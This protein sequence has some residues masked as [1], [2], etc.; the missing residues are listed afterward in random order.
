VASERGQASVEWVAVVLLVALGL[1]ALLAFGPRVDGRSY[2]GFLA[3]KIACAVRG[4]CDDGGEQLADAYG[5]DDAVLVRRYAPG[6]VYEPGTFTL[7]IDFR[8]CR[9][10]RCA[11]AP[12]DPDLDVHRSARGGRQ[13]TVFT[14]VIHSNGET[15]IQYWL[16]YP[17]STSTVL[18]AAG[19]WN[20]VTGR[21]DKYPGF[22]DDDWESYQVR[23]G[24]DGEVSVR[25][26]S[27]HGYQWC[28]QRRCANKWGSNTGWTR[29]SRGSHAGH[30]PLKAHVEGYRRVG[31]IPF[32]EPTLR[33]EPR[34]PGVN[35]RER[36]STPGG[37]KLVPLET[38]DTR[39]YRPRGGITPPWRKK[40]YRD[41]R[42]N[43][44]A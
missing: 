32:V 14:R 3:H 24:R 27:H 6:L 35:L 40:V 12:D 38:L 31:R 43:S 2:G 11:D 29:V 5:D 30:I 20:K 21:K 33:Y 25:A 8:E 34:I 28:K 44:T 15:F 17:D 9:S 19:V 13:A 42:S 23:I 26:S 36:T 18:N 16:Y 22:H 10:H 39:S 7:P 4:G 37:L 41:P 1:A